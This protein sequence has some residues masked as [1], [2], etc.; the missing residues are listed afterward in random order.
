MLKP[1]RI[2]HIILSAS[3]LTWVFYTVEETRFVQIILA[4]TCF[5]ILGI[6]NRW[7]RSSLLG[8]ISFSIIA[9]IGIFRELPFG[10]MLAGILFAYLAY[11]LSKFSRRLKFAEHGR[12]KNIAL[13]TRVH[14][15]RIALMTLLG[16]SISTATLSWQNQL[17]LSWGIFVGVVM[18]WWMGTFLMHKK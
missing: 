6:F 3:A 2:A 14:L 9:L 17:D 8:S 11:D 7:E 1:S 13:I 15:S 16:L 12:E 10:W 4:L 5:W 18:L